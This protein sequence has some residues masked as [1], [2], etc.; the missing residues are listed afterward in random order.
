MLGKYFF[1]CYHVEDTRMNEAVKEVAEYARL[2][3][4]ARQ[5]YGWQPLDEGWGQRKYAHHRPEATIFKK[6]TAHICL[7]SCLLQ[8]VAL[9]LVV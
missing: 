4:A 8:D 6:R 7:S 3:F 9:I 1:T 2:V 5:I